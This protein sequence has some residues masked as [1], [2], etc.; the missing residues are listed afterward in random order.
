MHLM[1]KHSRRPSQSIDI[2]D[3]DVTPVMN[4]FIILI[5][6]L[7]SMVVFTHFA[8]IRFSLPANENSGTAA[9]L[10]KP[11]LKLTI[12]LDNNFV[13]LTH[14]ETVIDSLST[15]ATD[16]STVVLKDLLI[17]CRKDPAFTDEVIIAS[18]DKVIFESIVKV[19]DLCRDAGFSK[20]GMTNATEDPDKGV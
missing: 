13:M 18:R 1:L 2:I 17:R 15:T 10:Q 16:P 3:V 7:I 9:A 14:G 20:I 19:M 5:P 11:V 8:V 4:L 6:F 12:V